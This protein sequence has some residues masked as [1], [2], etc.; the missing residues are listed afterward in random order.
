VR[1]T[2]SLTAMFYIGSNVLD[3]PLEAQRAVADG[4]EIC[5]R[6]YLSF[7]S[8]SSSS[9]PCSTIDSILGLSSNFLHILLMTLMNPA[10][11]WSHNYMTAFSNEGVFA[12]LWYSMKAIKLVTG[13]TP[14]CWRVRFAFL[15]HAFLFPSLFAFFSLALPL[16]S[17]LLG[18]LLVT[19]L[20]L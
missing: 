6:E 16:R 17:S 8:S 12:E 10:D 19:H 11:T 13:V 4:H 15:F 1:L 20:I 2:F 14:R 5:V 9:G 18:L 7:V 3:W